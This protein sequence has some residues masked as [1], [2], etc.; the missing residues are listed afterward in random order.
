MKPFFNLNFD[1][2]LYPLDD[3]V[4]AQ[5][6]E[7]MVEIVELTGDPTSNFSVFSEVVR[8]TFDWEEGRGGKHCYTTAVTE[9]HF[10]LH[11]RS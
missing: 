6:Y 2:L 10:L 5:Y 3:Q 11:Q 1:L 4:D 7:E 9:A 8:L